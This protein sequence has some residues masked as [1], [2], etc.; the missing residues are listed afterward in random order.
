[1][2]FS[3]RQ[4]L[5]GFFNEFE[6]KFSTEKWE[7]QG[8]KVW[9]I[10]KNSLF[11]SLFWSR[12]KKR[13]HIARK[14]SLF[15]SFKPVIKKKLTALK[16]HK[17]QFDQVD[18]LFFSGG[19]FREEFNGESFNK[20]YDPIGDYLEDKNKRFLFLEYGNKVSQKTYKNRGLNIQ[21]VYHYFE[22]KQENSKPDFSNWVG[23]DDFVA[24]LQDKFSDSNTSIY[25]EIIETLRKVLIWKV[26]FDWILDQ[27]KPQQ[28]FLL[29]YYNL[30]CFGLLL[31]ARNRNISCIDIQH[32]AQGVFH[33]AY[34]GFK[35]DYSML[36][37]VFWLWDQ[38]TEKQLKEN[39][40]FPNIHT[41]VGGNPWHH[42]LNNT[43]NK[44]S[45]TKPVILYTLQPLDPLLDEYVI[46]AIL[47]TKQD[48]V[49]LIRS[50]PRIDSDS[51]NQL[52]SKLKSLEIF[53]QEIW[54]L[55]NNTPLPLLLKEVD[56]HISKFSGC[57][58]EAADL[59]TFSVIL[60]KNGESSFSHL[61]EEGIAVGGIDSNTENL[62]AAIYVNLGKKKVIS[63]VDL[64]LVMDQLP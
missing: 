49:W 28:I 16:F 7:Y 14:P 4:E 44:L 64:D 19:N 34:S 56:L 32:G 3:E 46:E 31:A 6:R 18:S 15:Q 22:T 58:S 25:S 30:P 27:T 35:E 5:I 11:L 33:P 24:F 39:L 41:K 47:K 9:P 43:R 57:I 20:Y 36:P 10:L 45:F 40:H 13:K 2:N 21:L 42:F 62:I 12:M 52:I 29:S 53:D 54:G 1:M 17:L 23:M 26:S 38:K 63:H 37:T 60:E 61:I 48:F 55:A 59:G 50:H 51:K 8:V